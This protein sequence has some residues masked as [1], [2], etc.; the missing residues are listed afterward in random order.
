MD[1]VKLK[2]WSKL[3]TRDGGVLVRVVWHCNFVTVHGYRSNNL[4]S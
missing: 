2:L 1:E 3:R 4:V